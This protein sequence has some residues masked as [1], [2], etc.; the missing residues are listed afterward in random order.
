MEKI[1]NGKRYNTSTAK[2]I[3][4]RQENIT[5]NLDYLYQT[6]YRKKSGEFFLLG[7][8]GPRT[9]YGKPSESGGWCSGWQIIPLTYEAAQEWAEEYLTA[10]EYEACFG[11]VAEGDD[12]KTPM[13]CTISAAALA[14]LRRMSSQSGQTMSEIV[15]QLI[16]DA[17]KQ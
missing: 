14:T 13:T 2:E 5:N 16:L 6:L 1:I 12:S 7:E 9:I 10:S 17:A 8:G 3:G 15:D 4:A 11:T